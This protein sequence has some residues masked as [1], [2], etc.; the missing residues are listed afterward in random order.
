[1]EISYADSLKFY[2]IHDIPEGHNKENYF[3]YK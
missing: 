2:L 3:N 1:M